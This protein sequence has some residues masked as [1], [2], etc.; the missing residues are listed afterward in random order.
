MPDT[1]RKAGKHIGRL[2]N[3]R[4]FDACPYAQRLILQNVNAK[5]IPDR[6]AIFLKGSPAIVV[7]QVLPAHAVQ[8]AKEVP[9]IERIELEVMAN[10]QSA[11]HLYE[12]FGFQH[13]GTKRNLVGTSFG[14]L[15][16]ATFALKHGPSR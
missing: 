15:N 16:R 11:I 9:I 8:C 1:F 13:E 6:P 4:Q 7:R 12:S 5:L 14:I 2:E 3:T 10:N